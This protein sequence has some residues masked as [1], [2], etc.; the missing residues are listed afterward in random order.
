MSEDE[1]RQLEKDVAKAK[2]VASDWASQ[3]H[4]LVEDRFPAAYQELPA[5]SQS[6]FAAGEQWADLNRQ[7]QALKKRLAA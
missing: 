4:D 1:L 6:A 7:L 2:R 5:L 3:I